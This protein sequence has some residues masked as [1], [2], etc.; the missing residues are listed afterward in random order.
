MFIFILLLLI[1]DGNLS[2]TSISKINTIRLIAVISWNTEN[3]TEANNCRLV[4][5]KSGVGIRE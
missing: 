3:K 4:S 1:S 2:Y 5:G